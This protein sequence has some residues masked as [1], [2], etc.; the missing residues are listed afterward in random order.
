M[1]CNCCLKKIYLYFLI[2]LQFGYV[3]CF[4]LFGKVFKA[5]AL[6]L[7]IVLVSMNHCNT[8]FVMMSQYIL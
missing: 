6:K 3:M 4:L 5:K 8:S 1:F 7:T 2:T